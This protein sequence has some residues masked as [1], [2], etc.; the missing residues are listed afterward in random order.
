[1]AELVGLPSVAWEW[2]PAGA[3][4]CDRGAFHKTRQSIYFSILFFLHSPP[5]CTAPA[6]P[7]LAIL[8]PEAGLHR[9]ASRAAPCLQRGKP[10]P[11]HKEPRVSWDG[12]AAARRGNTAHTCRVPSL[13]A[14]GWLWDKHTAQKGEP[15][16]LG[17]I[18]KRWE[19]G[20]PEQEHAGRLAGA[21]SR[22][23][24]HATGQGLA[25]HC[26]AL[27]PAI[28]SANHPLVASLL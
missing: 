6:S 24:A 4:G 11:Q 13:A 8:R 16:G 20:G 14:E 25:R 28:W 17:R 10:A 9:R 1:M 26:R 2:F 3:Q 7:D 27:A 12:E 18:S 23:A 15:R 5:G 19:D 21:G 22:Q